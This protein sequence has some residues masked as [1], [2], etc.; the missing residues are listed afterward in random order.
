MKILIICSYT[1]SIINFR[2]ELIKELIKKGYDV[3]ISA[4]KTSDLRKKQIESLG[5]RLIE[6]KLSRN[7]IN[8][9]LDLR[10]TL[11]L[12]II[13]RKIKPNTILSYTIKPVIYGSIAG[14]INKVPNICSLITG[15]GYT[16]SREESLLY[17][18]SSNLY[19]LALKFNKF[20][21]F[22]N[23]DDLQL[24][25]TKKILNDKNKTSVV[26]G[27]GVNIEHFREQKLDN[28]NT[29]L[30]VGRYLKSKG[31]KEYLEAAKIIKTRHPKTRFLIAG[32]TDGG[33]DSVDKK[34]ID[35]YVKNGYIEDLGKLKDVRPALTICS[36][37]IL[38]SYREG[39]ARSVLEAMS[40]GRAIIT[41]DAPGC[42]QT[43]IN[44]HNG[45]LIEP[46]SIDSLTSA[47]EYFI[48]NPHLIEK[49]G[50]NSRELAKSKYDVKLVNK[51][52]INIIENI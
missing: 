37:F 15:L 46:K 47:I 50:K 20:V 19:K 10:Y 49:F 9:F 29:F 36:V 7:K 11:E 51:K 22:Q 45:L 21:I 25:K 4:P 31:T 3:Y 52:M 12:S 43:V 34:T 39:T 6:T 32:W 33:P 24:F 41:T 44:D 8:P 13:I 35:Y 14:K 27:S 5:A 16:F 40:T 1:E 28:K 30:M 48:S 42:R 38:P 18:I 23:D 17:K 2:G 26:N